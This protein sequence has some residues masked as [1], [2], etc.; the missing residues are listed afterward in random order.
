MMKP[1]IY[2]SLFMIYSFVTG[3][4]DG[5]GSEKIYPS[6]SAAAV[7]KNTIEETTMLN[8][9]NVIRVYVDKAG[10]ITAG[11]NPIDLVALDSAFSKLKKTHGTVYY[12]RDHVQGDP[13]AESMKVIGL[14]A[15]YRLVVKFFTDKTF[16]QAVDG[17]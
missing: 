11:G 14:V 4:D 16:S 6:D 10:K 17:K 5:G 3:C 2:I 13:P 12:S 1:I 15:K 9:T 8:D 7:N